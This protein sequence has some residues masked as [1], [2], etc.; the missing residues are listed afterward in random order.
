MNWKDSKPFIDYYSGFP[1][2]TPELKFRHG[3]FF[4]FVQSQIA[5]KTLTRM[6]DVLILTHG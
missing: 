6:R 3:F 1:K 4:F 2:G 5:V